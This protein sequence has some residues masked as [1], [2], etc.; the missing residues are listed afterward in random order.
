[1]PL[2]TQKQRTTITRKSFEMKTLRLYHTGFQVIEQ[3]E[4]D[5]GRSNADF[6]RGFY[7]SD[8]EEFSRRWARE[9]KG[10]TTYL[11]IYD[12]DTDDLEIK[13]F[14]RDKEWFGYISANRRGK[15]DELFDWDV[16]V[17]PIAN[18]TIY[19]VLGITTSGLL[20]EEKALEVLKAG[21]EYIQVVIKT[22]KA[23]SHLTFAGAEEITPDEM[24]KYRE[25]LMAEEEQFQEEFVGILSE[26]E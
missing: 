13:T 20:N 3:P 26:E 7:L 17:G 25:A 21:P 24:E 23:L 9:L 2:T 14:S 1:M 5:H 15:A 6:G 18:D 22:E 8:D 19:D 10:S 16:I 4:V 12:L 11:N